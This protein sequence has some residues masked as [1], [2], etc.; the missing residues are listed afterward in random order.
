ME[1]GH[2][3]GAVGRAMAPAGASGGGHEAI[4]RR[5]GG[6]ACGGYGVNGAVAGIG[7]EIAGAI[8]GMDARDQAA[9]DRLLCDLDGTPNKA[10]LGANAVVAVSMAVL[11]AA[12]ADAREPL[13]RYLAEGRKV[14]VPL[15][16]DRKS[17]RLNSSH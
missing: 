9:V 11:H 10:R 1:V 3:S 15:P 13:W 2:E 16:E 14:R 12:A 6:D 7:A 8:A 5:D 17:T 4:D